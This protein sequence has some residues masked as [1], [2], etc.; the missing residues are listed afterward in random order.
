MSGG[1]EVASDRLLQLIDK[2]V[3]VSQVAT[4]CKNFTEAGILVHSY[5]MYGYPTQTAQ[6]TI[7]SLEMVRQLFEQGIIQSGFWH[8]FAMTAH[9]PVGMNPSAYKSKIINSETGTFA[10]NDL[11]YVEENGIDHEIFSEGLRVSLYN[12]MHGTG[13]DMPLQ[14]W[15]EDNVPKTK[16]SNTFIESVLNQSEE[17]NTRSSARMLFL[18]RSPLFKSLPHKS[19]SSIARTNNPYKV[20]EPLGKWLQTIFPKLLIGKHSVLSF[21]EFKED[22]EKNNSIE[23][24]QFWFGESWGFIAIEW[25]YCGIIFRSPR[26]Q[27][28]IQSPD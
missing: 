4:V 18:G 16:I 6:E 28:A 24:E 25:A 27:T 17:I 7:D 22:F 26:V 14:D 10:N 13:F 5:L 3:T 15:F 2:G 1:L 21:K 23:F 19:H 8:R 11:E 20:K 9:S 12:Y